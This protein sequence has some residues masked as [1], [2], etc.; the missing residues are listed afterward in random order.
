MLCPNCNR[1]V[2]VAGIANLKG[3]M[4]GIFLCRCGKEWLK[5]VQ[6]IRNHAQ[7]AVRRRHPADYDARTADSA[8]D[9]GNWWIWPVLVISLGML[10]IGACHRIIGG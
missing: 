4:N 9:A 1:P 7:T 2:Q 5:P 6:I 10:V 3:K 8:N